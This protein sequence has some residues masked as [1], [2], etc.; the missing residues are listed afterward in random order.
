[1]A[2]IP[3]N[4]LKT[5]WLSKMR[6]SKF[7]FAIIL[8]SVGSIS[9]AAEKPPISI[10]PP[11]MTAPPVPVPAP[12]PPV[13]VPPVT[14]PP[15]TVPPPVPEVLQHWLAGEVQNLLSAID[16]IVTRGLN[17]SDYAASELRAALALGEG[18]ALDRAAKTSFDLLLTDM[19]KRC[20]SLC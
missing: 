4:G 5:G 7:L 6:R 15:V 10:L 14:V 12:T 18:E 20:R 9:I 11:S 16:G 3:S 19:P 2:I 1:M 17:P 8:A 13:V